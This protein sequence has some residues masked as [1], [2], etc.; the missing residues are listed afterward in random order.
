MRG[1]MTSR[2]RNV[3]V[4]AYVLLWRIRAAERYEG[5]R[6]VYIVLNGPWVAAPRCFFACI[7]LFTL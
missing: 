2:G 4:Y 7:S 6:H 3:V 1:P 5:S